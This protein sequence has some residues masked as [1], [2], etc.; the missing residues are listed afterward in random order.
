[1]SSHYN[2]GRPDFYGPAFDASNT[3]NTEASSTSKGELASSHFGTNNKRQVV[4][5]KGDQAAF[6]GIQ[7][8]KTFREVQN[9]LATHEMSAHIAAIALH[10]WA[11]FVKQGIVRG[12]DIRKQEQYQT[13]L[14]GLNAN[15]LDPQSIANSLWALGI[16]IGR[17]DASTDPYFRQIVHEFIRRR[18]EFA[19]QN[20]SISVWAMATVDYRDDGMLKAISKEVREK[21]DDFEAQE[22][23]NTTWAFA[24]LRYKDDSMYDILAQRAVEKMDSF[25]SQ[26]LSNTAWAYST[27]ARQN[28]Y[29]FNALS[30]QILKRT[31]ELRPLDLSN[32][33]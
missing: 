10:R 11:R 5:N 1:M 32:I 12:S 17:R 18:V 23:S 3:L 22:V 13:V 26:N 19:P 15:L 31:E 30:D 28:D 25:N 20:L 24:T 2:F 9:V 29:L 33:A 8:A 27:I 21:L 4:L 14:E 16:I 6:D 7:R